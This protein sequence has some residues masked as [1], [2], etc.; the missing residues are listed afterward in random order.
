[1]ATSTDEPAA[2]AVA[3]VVMATA[4][5]QPIFAA[6]IEKEC[7]RGHTAPAE[8]FVGVCRAETKL[9]RKL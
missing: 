3:A 6:P 5:D 1:M 2:V 8:M 7:S 4:A 9:C